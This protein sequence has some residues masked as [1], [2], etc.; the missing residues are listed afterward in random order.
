MRLIIFFLCSF[1]AFYA[2]AQV[3]GYSQANAHSHND[4]EKKN[5]FH[6]AYN[7]KFGSIEADVHLVNGKLLV[8]HDSKD[9]DASKTLELLYLSPLS[10]Y[11]DKKGSY[12][13]SSTSKQKP[14][15]PWND[16]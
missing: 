13:C 15:Q 12:N 11:N 9:L 3:N 2:T 14:F 4:Y 5:P 8:G 16:W 10:Q 7:E 1:L 6:E